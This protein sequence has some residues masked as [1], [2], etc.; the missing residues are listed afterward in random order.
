MLHISGITKSFGSANVLKTI[1]LHIAD[2]EFVALLGPSG[3]GKT[4]LLRII[5]GFE[6]ADAGE[7][8]IGNRIVVQNALSVAPERRK[9]GMVFQDYALFPHLSVK[10]NVA[11]GLPRSADRTELVKLALTA[12]DMLEW[13]DVMPHQLSGGQQ[14]RIALARALAPKPGI[15][16]LDEPFSNLDPGLRAHVRA[17]I[18]RIIREADA[19]AILVTHDQEE[20]LSM[21]D[22]VAVLLDGE[23]RQYDSPHAVYQRPATE[24][25]AR[26]VG[27]AHFLDGVITSEGIETEIGV[28]PI[29]NEGHE[30]GCVETVMLRP[31]SVMVEPAPA[32]TVAAPRVKSV[33]FFGKDQLLEVQLASGHIIVARCPTHVVYSPG[34]PVHIQVIWPLHVMPGVQQQG[35]A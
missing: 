4:T 1:D 14:Q 9:V 17:D 13:I 20:A 22:R 11:F 29:E 26:F 19:T 32:D 27:D 24:E 18:R 21:S 23:L 7:I 25:V 2:G 15:V 10:D 28:L 31:E 35:E 5:A 3:S 12:V 16:L 30:I 33:V 8:R 6:D 34:D